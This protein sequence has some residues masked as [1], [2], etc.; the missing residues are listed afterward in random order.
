M[1]P[2]VVFVYDLRA[3]KWTTFTGVWTTLR[4]TSEV[5]VPSSIPASRSIYAIYPSTY[6]ST[7]LQYRPDY[8]LDTPVGASSGASYFSQVVGLP[9]L[10]VDRAQE[11]RL[12]KVFV[13]GVQTLDPA[14]RASILVEAFSQDERRAKS[15]TTRDNAYTWT[16][17]QLAAES[18]NFFLRA[19]VV[20]QRGR[21]LRCRL[22]ITPDPTA[23]LGGEL[24]DLS[25]LTY[26]FGV[27]PG[28]GKARTRAG[29]ST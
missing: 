15:S 4:D 28:R 13:T 17:A 29:A 2:G 19:R 20:S 1:S 11:M 25:A 27:L 14:D 3:S 18:A 5:D 21:A 24:F 22:T 8:R 23:Y 12:W 16:A 10:R 7:Y 9:W 26:D 6:G